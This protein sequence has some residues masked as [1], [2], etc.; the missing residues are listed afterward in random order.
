MTQTHAATGTPLRRRMIEDMTL[1]GLATGTR[2]A[3]VGAIRSL[4]AR[5]RRAPDRL[6][7]EEVRTYLLDLRERGAARG[8]FKIAWFAI[9]FLFTRTLGSDWALFGKKRSASPSRSGFPTPCPTFRLAGC[10][11][12]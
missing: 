8:T 5:Y 6:T 3:Y 7:E 11:A 12:A 2:D 1:A 9:K 10:S 4:A